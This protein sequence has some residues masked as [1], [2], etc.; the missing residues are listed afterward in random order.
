[1]LRRLTEVVVESFHIETNKDA[2]KDLLK[3]IT[4]PFS[5]LVVMVRDQFTNDNVQICMHLHMIL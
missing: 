4:K 1:M 2:K 3:V 5:K